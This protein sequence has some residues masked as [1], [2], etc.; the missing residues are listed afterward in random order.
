MDSLLPMTGANASL[1]Q[2]SPFISDG[3]LREQGPHT[4]T[5][6]RQGHFSAAPGTGSA[7]RRGPGRT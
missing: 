2:L 6:G 7:P 1:D 4:N 3:F 5:G